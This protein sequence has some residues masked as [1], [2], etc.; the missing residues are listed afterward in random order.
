M[1]LYSAS[2]VARDLRS[3]G[4]YQESLDISRRV[5]NSFAAIGGRENIHWLYA[6]EGFA[7]ALR[8]AGHHWDALQE[9]EHVF[10][11]YQDYLGADHTYTLRSAAN[12]I[13]A[14]RARGDIAGAEE[15]AIETRE[16]CLRSGHPDDL[17]SAVL[18]NL[19]SVLRAAGR[20]EEALTVDEQARRMLIRLYGDQHPMTLAASVNY[21]TDLAACGRLGEALQVG[22]ELVH[23]CTDILGP[24]HPD[25]LMANANLALDEAAAGNQAMADRRLAD[26]LQR[27]ADTLTA[28]HPEARAAAQGVRLIAAIEPLN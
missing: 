8:K 13:N 16:A 24:D 4:R 10:Q 27:Y 3:L 22:Y 20:P 19:A 17:L 28:E 7:T 12:L 6:S 5:A 26:V 2:A 25:T 11:R 23:N 15:L 14:R 9:N 1:T 18:V 21:A